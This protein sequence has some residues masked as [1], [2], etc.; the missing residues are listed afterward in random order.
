MASDI[1]LFFFHFRVQNSLKK[2][3]IRAVKLNAVF[4]IGHY[5]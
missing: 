3:I 2:K 1:P 5:K 4:M